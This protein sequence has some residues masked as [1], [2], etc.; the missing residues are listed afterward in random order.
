TNFGDAILSRFKVEE[1]ALEAGLK[2]EE[3]NELAEFICFSIVLY[4]RNAHAAPEID[5]KL[6]KMKIETYLMD[7]AAFRN[8]YKHQFRKNYLRLRSFY[9]RSISHTTFEWAYKLKLVR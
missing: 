4:L 8:W 3:D 5:K 1:Y 9:T 6:I 2:R 7:N